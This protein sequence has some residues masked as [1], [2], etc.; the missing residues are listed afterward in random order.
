MLERHDAGAVRLRPS[1][2]HAGVLRCDWPG[3]DGAQI[4]VIIPTRDNPG[5]LG[6]MIDSLL[7]LAARP[8]RVEILVVDNG[9]IPAALPARPGIRRLAV[10]GAFN[11]SHFNNRAA[12]EAADGILVFA[13]DDMRML[14]PGWDERLAGLLGRPAIG[15]VGARLLYPAGGLQHAGILTGWRGSLV[16]DGLGAAGDAPGPE[17]R[18]CRPRRVSAVTGAFLAIASGLF[19]AAGGF[20]AEALPVAYSDVDLC[21]RIRARGLAVL[22]DAELE[23]LHRESGTRGPEH[24]RP[25]DAARAAAERQAFETRWPSAAGP[26]PFCHPAFADFGR[27]CQHV[28]AISR[29]RI[30]AALAGE[31]AASLR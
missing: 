26:D 13:N 30:V 20:D 10:P 7:A 22:W 12:A 5:E 23:L 25:E 14:T 29:E 6:V 17:G 21:F 31:G 8:E 9:D 28:A 3:D 19:E 27:P 2:A 11:W 1:P 24:L 18:W 15:I 16:H 4:S